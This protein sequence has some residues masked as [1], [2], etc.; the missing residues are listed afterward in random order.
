[1]SKIETKTDAPLQTTP[2]KKEAISEKLSDLKNVSDPAF[3]NPKAGNQ[4]CLSFLYAIS[5]ASLP[6]SETSGKTP[7]PSAKT[8]KMQPEDREFFNAGLVQARKICKDFLS[9][10]IRYDTGISPS[11]AQA[12]CVA[13]NAIERAE[14]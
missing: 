3:R 8:H 7:V 9:F 13:V 5:D 11:D 1:M 2:S 6:R 14:A 12:L 10:L 4:P